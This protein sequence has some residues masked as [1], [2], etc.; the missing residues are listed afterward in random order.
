MYHSMK[1]NQIWAR[2]KNGRVLNRLYS[3]LVVAENNG[4][5]MKRI[6]RKTCKKK[7][8]ECK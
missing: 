2:A 6:P 1:P 7:K 3:Q 5:T 8:M 4:I